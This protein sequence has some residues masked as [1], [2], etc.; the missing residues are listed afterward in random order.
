MSIGRNNDWEEKM[1]GYDLSIQPL[2]TGDMLSFKIADVGTFRLAI[3]ADDT[4][5]VRG[6]GTTRIGYAYVRSDKKK[7]IRGG[8]Y[9]GGS[10]GAGVHLWN[11][12]TLKELNIKF[13]WWAY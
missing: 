5:V 1:S 10:T 4:A 6:Y 13:K 12:R 7:A 3:V 9:S 8:P 11:V 2:K